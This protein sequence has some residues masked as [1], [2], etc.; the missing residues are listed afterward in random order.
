MSLHCTL[1]MIR[2]VNFILCMFYHNIREKEKVELTF[3]LRTS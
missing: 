1:Q 2:M 3:R